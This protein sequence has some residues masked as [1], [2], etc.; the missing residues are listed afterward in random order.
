MPILEPLKVSMRLRRPEKFGKKWPMKPKNF[1]FVL[2]FRKYNLD[3]STLVRTGYAIYVGSIVVSN[4]S[5]RVLDFE[6][7]ELPHCSSGTRQKAK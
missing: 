3:F 2:T 5:S 1:V 6:L 4:D 7:L